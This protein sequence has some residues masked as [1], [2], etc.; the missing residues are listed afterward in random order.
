[1]VSKTCSLCKETKPLPEF[2]SRGDPSR[3]RRGT[4]LP[5]YKERRREIYRNY[6]KHHNTERRSR[7]KNDPD[8]RR[9]N[10][11][12]CKRY[13]NKNKKKLSERMRS[14]RA[15]IRTE[16]L[17]IYGGRCECCRESTKEFLA[18][19]HVHGGGAKHRKAIGPNKI[20][21][22]LHDHGKRLP[23]FQILCHNCNMAKSCYGRCPHNIPLIGPDPKGIQGKRRKH[24]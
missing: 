8:Y 1:M 24:A 19:D 3:K 21:K 5:C 20:L 17:E 7:W 9:K 6:Y 10:R 13:R 18:L 15:K 11:E 4:C 16:V 14:T 12:S 23:D 22:I 2:P